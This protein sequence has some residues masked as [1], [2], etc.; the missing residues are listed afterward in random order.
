M[1]DFDN[2]NVL[3]KQLHTDDRHVYLNE[4]EVRL[5]HLGINIG[6]EQDGNGSSY[7]RPVLILKRFGNICRVVPM[8]SK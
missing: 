1:K 5:A 8:T 7:E 6:F 2:W 3:K 4:R